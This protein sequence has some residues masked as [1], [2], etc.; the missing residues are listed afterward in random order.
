MKEVVAKLLLE[1]CGIE[2]TSVLCMW[3]KWCTNQLTVA[4]LAFF[5][6]S[7]DKYTPSTSTRTKFP[8]IISEAGMGGDN[9]LVR[10]AGRIS[11]AQ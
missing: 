4:S 8:T 9:E 1:F 2:R 5:K 7:S 6:P 10:Q 3:W 11:R